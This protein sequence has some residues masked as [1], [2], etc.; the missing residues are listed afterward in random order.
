MSFHWQSFTFGIGLGATGI[1]LVAGLKGLSLRLQQL[2]AE[3]NEQNNDM[4]YPQSPGCAPEQS[5]FVSSSSGAEPIVV[6]PRKYIY[7]TDEILDWLLPHGPFLEVAAGGGWLA[8]Q[9]NLK[10]VDIIAFDRNVHEN[11]YFNVQIRLNGEIEDQYPDR[12]LLITAGFDVAIS[13]RKYTGNKIILGGYRFE[14]VWNDDG[15]KRMCGSSSKYLEKNNVDIRPCHEFM[16]EHGWIKIDEK[17]CINSKYK[18]R[19]LHYIY[20]I[21]VRNSATPQSSS[22][23][24]PHTN[25]SQSNSSDTD[26]DLSQLK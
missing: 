13:V 6:R 12:T 2:E 20:R 25:I 21:Y 26:L 3:R 18:Y 9:L 7:A 1:I 4:Y 5:R 19:G 11:S 22:S 8:Q 24:I 15:T 16:E 23:V 14:E 10:G 17:E